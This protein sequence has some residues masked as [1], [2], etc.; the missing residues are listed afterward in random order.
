MRK[1]ILVTIGILAATQAQAAMR[2]QQK[3]YGVLADAVRLKGYPCKPSSDGLAVGQAQHMG[4]ML[5]KVYCNNN[6][7]AY[8]VVTGGNTLCVEPWDGPQTCR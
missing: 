3:D 2:V 5:F 7:I 8:R 1:I 4:G 6:T